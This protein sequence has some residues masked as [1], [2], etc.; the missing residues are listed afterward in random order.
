MAREHRIISALGRPTCRSRRRS[1]C[2]TSR[3]TARRSTSWASSTA[4]SCARRRETRADFPEAERRAMASG[5]RRPGHPPV[6]LDAVGLGDLAKRED[7][8]ARQLNRWRRQWEGWK[9]R[10]LNL[11]E[12]VHQRLPDATHK[13]LI[14]SSTLGNRDIFTN[15]TI[16]RF[17]CSFLQLSNAF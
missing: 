2:T 17:P 3:S 8:V 9:T 11:V 7:Y 16:S 13:D 1:I 12:D 14:S 6:D 10:E 15:I 4:R 5:R